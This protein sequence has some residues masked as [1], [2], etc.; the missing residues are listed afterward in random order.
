MSRLWAEGEALPVRAADGLP[1]A[2]RWR[3]AWHP[4]RHIALS[5]QLDVFWW[6]ERV[7]RDYFKILTRDMVMVIYHDLLDDAWALQRIYD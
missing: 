5:W 2:I 7:Y 1:S 4:I 6:R 3:G